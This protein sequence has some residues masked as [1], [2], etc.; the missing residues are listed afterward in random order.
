L[1]TEKRKLFKKEI[2][3]SS[4]L[5]MTTQ[6]KKKEPAYSFQKGSQ[7][8]TNRLCINPLKLLSGLKGIGDIGQIWNPSFPLKEKK[9]KK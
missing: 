9:K 7:E 3:L 8:V 5:L 4:S 6:K 1:G 2:Q